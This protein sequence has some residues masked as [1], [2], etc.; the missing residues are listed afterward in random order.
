MSKKIPSWL[1]LQ[2]LIDYNIFLLEQ[3]LK[4]ERGLSSFDQMIDQATGYDKV[5]Y[6][7]AQ[8]IMDKITKLKEEYYKIV[9][10]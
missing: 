4:E 2:Y 7:K 8:R 3:M 1:R 5:K 10:E 9:G 6:K